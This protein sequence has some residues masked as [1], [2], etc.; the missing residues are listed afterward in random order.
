MSE[1]DHLCMGCMIDKGMEKVCPVCGWEQGTMQE[2]PQHLPPGTILHD[3]Y[4]L[5]RVLGHGGFGITYLAWDVH[6]EMK[7]AIKEYMPR[8]FATRGSD[9]ATVSI[10]TWEL[11]THF[12]HGLNK[13]LDEAKILAQFSNHPGIVGVRDFFKENGTAYLVMYYL[14]GIDF[15]QYLEQQGGTI[16]FETAL[17]IMMPVMDALREVHTYGTLHRDISPDNIYITKEGQIKILDFGAAR[18]AM[19]DFNTSIS[20]ILK[21]GYAPEEQYRSKGKQGPWTDI[22][23]VAATIYRAIVGKTPPESL[24][25]LEEDIIEPP[26]VFDV[27]IPLEAENALMKA[28]SVKAANRFQSIAEFQQAFS[29]S[30]KEQLAHAESI[31]P[32]STPLEK[33]E[34]TAKK[35]F[36]VWLI[37]VL[38]IGT[39]GV[40]TA[41][42]LG[43]ILLI[44]IFNEDIDPVTE[45]SINGTTAVLTQ[46]SNES[47]SKKLTVPNVLDKTED[48]AK[49][50]ITNAGFKIGSIHYEENSFI[51]KGLIINQSMEPETIANKNDTVDLTIS[52]GIELPVDLAIIQ[53]EQL[54][55]INKYWDQG[56]ALYEQNNKEGS[57]KAYIQARDM[58]AELVKYNGDFDA[59]FAEGVLAR[60]VG[61][62]KEELGYYSYALQDNIKS[63]AILN[64]LAEKDPVFNSNQTELAISYGNLSWT[65]L[66]NNYP[67][68]A[69][70]TAEKGLSIDSNQKWMYANLAHGYLLNNQF[71]KAKQLYLEYKDELFDNGKPFKEFFL[72]DFTALENAGVTHPHFNEIKQLLNENTS[73]PTNTTTSN[74]DEIMI[75][76][77]AN[78]ISFEREDL[79]G[80]MSTIAEPDGI[81]KETEQFLQE[82][83][84][85]YN[86][87]KLEIETIQ[88]IA[89]NGESATVEVLQHLHYD[90]GSQ[91]YQSTNT[92]IHTLKM[93]EDSLFPWKI[94]DTKV[95]GE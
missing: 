9:Q 4:I 69:I 20:V 80:Y 73:N 78:A 35:R 44:G 71:E 39:L 1:F 6:L 2:S 42:I 52:K 30:T 5:G 19:N 81:N 32:P 87:I 21:P 17:K 67:K 12:D 79:P 86:N 24:D 15:K 74:E 68:E 45:E 66:L 43:V 50:F 88:N 95:K 76:I 3:K 72:E 90:D 89:I 48:D 23:A 53:T 31:R 26:S 27:S 41:G 92:L 82:F 16:S 75:T 91:T 47:S 34:P 8:N 94:Y 85:A 14:E 83:F 25:R 13:F 55:I 84:A 70:D 60:T 51:D 57:L 63:V 46:T 28:L 11:E 58:A 56:A 37:G 40:I 77:Y 10:Y 49:T 61:I 18:H 62:L 7:L 54:A 59:Q 22:Y 36:P 65:Y 38:S 93:T 29:L 33:K 64:D